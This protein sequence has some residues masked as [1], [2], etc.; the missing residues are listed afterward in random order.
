MGQGECEA[1]EVVRDISE[2]RTGLVDGTVVSERIRETILT[3]SC[4]SGWDRWMGL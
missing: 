3:G 4:E 2:E 1:N